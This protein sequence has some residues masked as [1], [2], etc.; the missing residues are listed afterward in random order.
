MS[1]YL[2]VNRLEFAVTYRCTSHCKHCHIGAA[3]RRAAPA[4]ID[5][6][7]AVDIVRRVAAAY[8]TRSIMT[9]GGEPLL[10]P[11]V[12]G[13]IHAAA[14]QSGI[15]HRSI[16]TNAGTPRTA[17]R[18]RHVSRRLAESGVTNVHISVDAF[19]QEHV[20]LA[21]VEANVRAYVEAGLPR[22]VWNPCW[23]V[24]P[25][26][27]NEWNRRTRAVLEALVHLPVE[28]SDGNVVQPD[29]NAQRWLAPYLPQ[30]VPLPSG[31]CDE[32]PYGGRLDRVECISIEPDGGIGICWEWEIGTARPGT[33]LEL[34]EAYDPHALPAAA[35]VLE[36]GIPALA[37]L[38][39]AR[40][41]APDPAGYYSICDACRALRRA[42]RDAHGDP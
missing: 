9:F 37:A 4:V 5:R 6:A 30:R 34:L 24:A 36:G 8:G 17:A 3:Q 13:A 7:L 12:V 38:C 35:A 25:D 28:A 14:R 22:L 10:Y 26:D 39:R 2:H 31:S 1:R 32:V 27:D 20:P 18:S 16:I 41:I 42:L 19:H 23:L 29:G 15:P 11:E 40:G 33:I 21:V